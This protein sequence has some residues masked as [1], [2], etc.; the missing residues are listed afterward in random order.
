MILGIVTGSVVAT[1]KDKTYLGHKILMVQPVDQHNK[2][3][4]TEVLAIDKVQAGA[5]DRVLVMTEGN[6]ARQLLNCDTIP[7]NMVITGIVDDIET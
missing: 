5:G 4:G 7:T 6:S 3:F 2:P 1:V